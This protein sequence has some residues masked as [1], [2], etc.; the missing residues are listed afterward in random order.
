LPQ[1]SGVRAFA[2]VGIDASDAGV[3]PDGRIGLAV[4][5]QLHFAAVAL[6]AAV[7][8]R[9]R[10]AFREHGGLHSAV[11][12]DHLR[13]GIIERTQD[14]P[15]LGVMGGVELADFMLV[16]AA[17]ILRGHDG[18]DDLA[19][20]LVGIRLLLESHVTFIAAHVAAVVFAG[21]PLGVERG[22]LLFVAVGAG[23][24]LRGHFLEGEASLCQERRGQQCGDE[25]QEVFGPGFHK[26]LRFV[27]FQWKVRDG[28]AGNRS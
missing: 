8:G 28:R 22:A 26:Y 23:L 13:Q 6:P 17:A 10:D 9:R 19:V 12:L 4:G 24:A 11:A 2:A 3:G 21:A 20:M 15:A 14:A 25:Q 5:Q 7:H 27:W 16:A 1:V 18:G